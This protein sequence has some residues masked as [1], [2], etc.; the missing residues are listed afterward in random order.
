MSN[1]SASTDSKIPDW[2]PRDLY[3]HLLSKK[4]D[5][6]R[7]TWLTEQRTALNHT[8][9]PPGSPERPE[10]LEAMN[11]MLLDTID[12]DKIH[13]AANQELANP[14]QLGNEVAERF[15]KDYERYRHVVNNTCGIVYPYTPF[16][17]YL[18]RDEVGAWY[19]Y[20]WLFPGRVWQS[21]WGTITITIDHITKFL[22]G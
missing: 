17:T 20:Y 7:H 14:E 8:L 12:M 9:P 6:L 21:N 19:V 4:V 22:G 3:K 10:A 11:T 5:D 1:S 16:E 2:C 15:R 13:E 18:H